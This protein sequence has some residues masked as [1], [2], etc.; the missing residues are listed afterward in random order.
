MCD[1]L[2][3]G[4]YSGFDSLVDQMTL[5][6]IKTGPSTY[7]RTCLVDHGLS[8]NVEVGNHI[9]VIPTLLSSNASLVQSSLHSRYFSSG[10]ERE[11]QGVPLM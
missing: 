10:W 3:L 4:R 5:T 1:V 11:P 8:G 9:E 2:F 6:T 7:R